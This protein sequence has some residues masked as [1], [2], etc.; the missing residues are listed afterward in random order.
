MVATWWNTLG[1]K[2]PSITNLMSLNDGLLD[3]HSCFGYDVSILKIFVA[4]LC[5]HLTVLQLLLLL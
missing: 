2:T 1:S 3:Y 4:L 5:F